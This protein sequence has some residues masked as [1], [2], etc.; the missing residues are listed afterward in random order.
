MSASK[1]PSRIGRLS[2]RKLYSAPRP[3]PREGFR[4]GA[5]ALPDLSEIPERLWGIARRRLEILAPLLRRRNRTLPARKEAANQLGCSLA[6]LY[7]LLRRAGPRP[8]LTHFLPRRRGRH[9]G[10]SQLPPRTEQIVSSTI[11]KYYLTRQQPRISALMVEI[12]RRC[13]TAGVTAP[14]RQAVQRRIDSRSPAEIMRRRRGHHAARDR[15]AP[16]TG[17]LTAAGPLELVQIDHTVV[18]VVVVDSVSRQPI[19]RPWLTLAIDVCTRCVLGFCLGLEAPSATSVALCIA[20]AALPKDGWLAARSIKST[21][22][23][24]G[25]PRRLHLDNAKEFHSEALRRGCEEH[26]IGL[27]YRPPRTPHY[28]GHIERLIGTMMGRVHL[29]PGTTFSGIEEKGTADPEASATLTLAELEK[30]LATAIIGVYHETLHRGL[31]T[32]PAVAWRKYA[33]GSDD[34]A[35]LKSV[36][37]DARRFLI[38]FLPLAHRLV[39]R[40]GVFL[41]SIC[42]WGDVLSTWVGQ[43]QKMIV[44]YDPR[45]LSRIYLRGPDGTYYDLPYRD[46]YRPSISLWEHRAA[47]K[48]LRE[49]GR[50]DVN[51]QSIFAAIEAMHRLTRK[52]STE[53]KKARRLRERARHWKEG[54]PP[55]MGKPPGESRVAVE[56]PLAD[57][58][59]FSSVEEWL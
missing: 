54:Q 56:P 23:A 35:E 11:E 34:P 57:G 32:T 43:P 29:L 2:G 45:D 1:S 31:G 49:Q 21:W 30:W 28:G 51:E 10:T 5:P 14:S 48:Y 24:S 19:R 18:D 55:L 17:S 53:T 38:D 16:V 42:Y 6:W 59:R 33:A 50:R 9:P 47:L 41:N 8:R 22:C 52:A 13:L 25:I 39:R 36:I 26:G 58:E 44:R 3:R 46:L 12:Q 27:L 7:E 4:R 40:E 20:H 15:F 37:A